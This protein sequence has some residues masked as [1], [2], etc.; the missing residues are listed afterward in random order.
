MARKSRAKQS[1][2]LPGRIKILAGVLVAVVALGI[3]GVKFLQSPRGSVFLLGKGVTSHYTRAQ[4]HIQGGLKRALVARGSITIRGKNYPVKRWEIVCPETADLIQVN[5][6]LTKAARSRGAAVQKSSEDQTGRELHLEIGSGQY[7]T[8]SIAV[9]KQARRRAVPP[10]E[11]VKKP[12]A[13][14]MLA[15]VVDDFGYS[16]NGTVE[17]FL[18]L[19]M[20]ITV[21]VIPSLPHSSE[22]A[23]L[24]AAR[25]KETILHLPMEPEEPRRHDVAPVTSAM[26][27]DEI[28]ALVAKYLSDIPGAAGVNNHMG[29]KATQDERVMRAV[30]GVLKER[31]LYFLDSLTSPRSIAYNAAVQRGVK[32]VQNDLFLDDDTQDPKLVGERLRRLVKLAKTR[33]EAVGIAHPR[34]WTLE[35]LRNN[36]AM[37]KS[38]GV[39][40]VFLSELAGD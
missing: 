24:A 39:R 26:T 37:L 9:I 25:K 33:G 5:L 4:D 29:S 18:A 23:A 8:H 40:L 6:A 13:G 3:A 35:A 30:L 32:A 17:A 7:T 19:D 36:E 12:A 27:S 16:K 28:A 38:S 15:L 20:P 1:K 22:V 14:P 11:T 34:R 31:K 21:A 10:E 2:A